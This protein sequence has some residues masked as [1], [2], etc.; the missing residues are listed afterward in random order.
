MIQSI[1]K[2][3][4]DLFCYSVGINAPFGNETSGNHDSSSPHEKTPQANDLVNSQGINEILFWKYNL[5]TIHASA[6]FSISILS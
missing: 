2:C 4:S 5:S 6:V 1:N 3:C